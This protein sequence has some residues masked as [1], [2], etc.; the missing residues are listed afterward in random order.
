MLNNSNAAY[1]TTSERK[2]GEVEQELGRVEV[3]CKVISDLI[4]N[5]EG[6]LQQ[7]LATRVVGETAQPSPPEPVRV[8]L[9][10]SVHQHLTGLA[11]ISVQLRSIIDRIEL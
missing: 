8:P 3:E 4:T 9:A 2:I 10:E 11:L 6:R 5:L 7:V 1:A